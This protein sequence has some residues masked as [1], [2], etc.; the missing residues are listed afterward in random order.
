MN[1]KS[2]H[3][4]R[5]VLGGYLAYLGV[6]ILME[7]IQ[8]KPSNEV[9]MLVLAVVFLLIGIAYAGN[10]IC[11]VFGIDFKKISA[12]WKIKRQEKKAEKLAAKAEKMDKAEV[13]VAK[14]AMSNTVTDDTL[15]VMLSEEERQKLQ[16]AQNQQKVSAEKQVTENKKEIPGETPGQN[17]TEKKTSEQNMPEQKVEPKDT[18]VV[19]FFAEVKEEALEDEAPIS[20]DAENDFEEK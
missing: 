9:L 10:S 4:I 13:T 15:P 2:G 19:D 3:A 12:Q 17:E 8:K 6:R 5:I 16:S 7:T 20:E 14:P 1:K 18:K 11:K